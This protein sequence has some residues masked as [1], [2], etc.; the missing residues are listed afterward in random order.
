MAAHKFNE[1]ELS[2]SLKQLSAWEL[3]NSKLHREFKFADFAHAFGFMSTAAVL[4]E[5]MNHH[6]EWFN[7]YN[8]VSVDLTTHDANGITE[9]DVELARLLDSIYSNPFSA[10]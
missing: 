1:Q 2:T 4:I 10:T 3:R 5:K 9:R 7:V 6:P 8:R